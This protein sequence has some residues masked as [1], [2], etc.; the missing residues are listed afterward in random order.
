LSRFRLVNVKRC[1]SR[2]AGLYR[3][4]IKA[5]EFNRPNN[6]LDILLRKAST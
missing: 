1:R 6:P 3:E 2:S 4:S 5:R